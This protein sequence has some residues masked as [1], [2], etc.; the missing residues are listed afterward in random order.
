MHRIWRSTPSDNAFSVHGLV[1]AAN[2][3][4]VSDCLSGHR[5]FLFWPI[6]EFSVQ[7]IN[8]YYKTQHSQQS[9]QVYT[10]QTYYVKPSIER[11]PPVTGR[12]PAGRRTMYFFIK[13]G[14][15]SCRLHLVGTRTA[16][17]RASCNFKLKIS[18]GYRPGSVGYVTINMNINMDM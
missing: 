18:T 6:I 13:W 12:A 7:Q 17:W 9:L 3:A 4:A 2:H 11:A 15:V 14:P 8:T 1:R 16:C 5:V 10:V